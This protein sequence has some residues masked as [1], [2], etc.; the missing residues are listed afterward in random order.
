MTGGHTAVRTAAGPSP[1][2]DAVAIGAGNIAQ[3]VLD[4]MAD[5]PAH[6]ALVVPVSWDD[7]RV[8]HAE[9]WTFGDLG[10][11]V[12]RW[13]RR[14]AGAGVGPGHRVLL[15]AP[16]GLDFYAAALAVLADGAT[17][18]LVDRGMSLA[19]ARASVALAAPD[20]IVVAPS[21]RRLR[22]L[23]PETR[24]IPRVMA[25]DEGARPPAEDRGRPGPPA[26]AAPRG[27]GDEAILSFTSG[28]TGRPKGADRTHGTLLAQHRALQAVLPYRPDDVDV[29]AWPVVVMHA[30]LNGTTS[31]LP[32][33]V[34]GRLDAVP[35]EALL[36]FAIDHGVTQLHGPPAFLRPLLQ[37]ARTR[38]ARPALRRI[39]ASGGPVDADLCRA[40][41]TA[42]PAAE[43]AVLYGSTE[44]EPVALCPMAEVVAAA[45]RGD[46][47]PGA[48]LLVGRP[49]PEIDVRILPP[50]PTPAPAPPTTGP[51]T[52]RDAGRH[53][54]AA[55]DRPDVG[56]GEIAFA[57]DHVLP[58]WFRDP[59]ADASTRTPLDGKDFLRSGDVGRIDER[60][61]LWLGGRVADA[62]HHGD[63]IVHTYEVE[64][65]LDA[66]DGVRRTALLATPGG[67]VLLVD[68]GPDR[69]PVPPLVRQVL[70]RAGLADIAVHGP[71]IIPVDGRHQSKVDRPTLRRRRRRLVAAAG[72]RRLR[73]GAPD[74]RTLP[75]PSPKGPS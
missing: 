43:G 24:R 33:V 32:P 58:R 70:H 62:V 44:A 67:P 25:L 49:V 14:L 31:V 26:A 27:P 1:I 4:R 64:P 68:T 48:G 63:R 30:L 19:R 10:H 34:P 56:W 37:R 6:P 23:L 59:A 9:A 38:A 45:D 41:A 15:L 16:P 7:R 22:R 18:V 52:R 50:A 35:A 47:R 72:V 17:L 65:V 66:L 74:R 61:R 46:L 2:P 54:G 13:R 36:S 39:V 5:R 21:L 8:G 73:R 75:T 40:V 57:G 12:T 60:G 28:S 42:F 29:S 3:P 69:R 20:A 11:A 51:A 53:H 71:V 55:G